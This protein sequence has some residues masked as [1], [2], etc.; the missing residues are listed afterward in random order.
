MQGSTPQHYTIADF[1]KW[2]DDQ[3]LE[4][5]PKFQRG[6]VWATPARSYLIESILR[7][8]PI[9]KLLLRT[10]VDRDSRRTIRDVVDGQQRLRTII[11]FANNK[12]VLG[13]KAGDYKG[14]RYSDLE[15]EEKDAFLAY[16]LTC[17]Q[18]INASDEDVL[19]VFL[20]INSYTVPVNAAELRNARFDTPFS[21][22]VKETV[23]Q[24]GPV[25]ALGVLSNRERVR[26]VDQS[27]V[28]EIY[29]FFLDGMQDGDENR[30]TRLY[31]NTLKLKDDELPDR[32]EMVDVTLE[33]A[34][35]LAE[36]EREP[37]VARPHFLIIVACV[38]YARDL[39]PPG[40]LLLDNVPTRDEMLTN[41][42][43]AVDRLREINSALSADPEDLPAR[44]AP[45]IEAKTSTQ[46]MRSRQIRFEYFSQAM[47][48]YEIV[49]R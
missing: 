35:L 49:N 45:L 29:G 33:A 20:R 21:S 38:M 8:Y 6:P 31:E 9:P 26:M 19:E 47:A 3:E 34:K 1:L 7:G 25:W 40:R 5:N 27:L 12:L 37:I 17:E 16:K 13:Q 42:E 2:H 41:V 11:D 36:F 22:L 46:R 32:E 10:S 30:I 23:R 18:L 15:D 14:M 39:L 43:V 24:L 44:F 28:A 4:L 48:G